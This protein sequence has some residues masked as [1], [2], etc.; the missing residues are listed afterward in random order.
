MAANDV[1]DWDTA[2]ARVTSA[3]GQKRHRF[4]W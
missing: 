3:M 4:G 1:R 2:A